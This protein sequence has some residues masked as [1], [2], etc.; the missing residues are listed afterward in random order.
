MKRVFGFLMVVALV[1]LAGCSK[2]KKTTLSVPFEKY[3]LDNGLTV[4]L[5]EDRSDP[6][7]SLVILYHVGSGREVLGKTGFAHLF[8]HMM[9]QRSENV[10]EDQFFKY[11]EGAGGDLNGGTSYDQ[12]MYYELL[13]KNALELAM[14]LESDR[15]GYMINT[16]TPQS[17]ATQQNVVQNEKRQGVDNRPYGFTE[18]VILKIFIP[19]AIH[20][21][22]MS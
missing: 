18:Y 11:I 15:M 6:I 1:I 8:E 16:V 3:T 7:T 5:S 2:D 21:A 22:G 19:R 14:W 4:I 12:T 9:F 13:P 20:T 17:F 10:G